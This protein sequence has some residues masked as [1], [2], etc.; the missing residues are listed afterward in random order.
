MGKL[1]IISIIFLISVTIFIAVTKPQMHKQIVFGYGSINITNTKTESEPV[2]TEIK[3]VQP[4]TS[5]KEVTTE[6]T[7]NN[8]N[9]FFNNLKLKVIESFTTKEIELKQ[10]E[11]KAEAEK[12]QKQA[13]ELAKKQAQEKAEAE[14]AQK[15][16]QELAKKQAQEKAEAEKAQKQAQELAKK[17]AQE[18]AK[19]QAQEKA[20]A[21]KAQKQAQEL[22]K[23]QAQELAKKQAQELAK[24]QAEEQKKLVEYQETII[25]NQWRANVCNKVTQNLDKKFA[26]VIPQGTIYT[27]SFNVDKNRR[28]TNVSVKISRGYINSTTN[29]GIYMIQQA[30]NSLNLSSVLNFPSGTQRTSVTVE[31]GIERS[32]EINTSTQLDASDFND[33]ETI[34]KQKYK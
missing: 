16:A 25:W 20:E 17:Q 23:K 29:Q 1:T 15:Q 21:E 22:A 14:K 11:E 5:A 31:S 7:D 2:K 10:T 24:K 18:L 34:T 13:Q 9:N 28:I 4:E 12:A 33:T 6:Q 26:S 8:T 32:A 19:K 30:I 27:Y 3:T